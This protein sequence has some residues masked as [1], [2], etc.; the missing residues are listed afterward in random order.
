MTELELKYMIDGEEAFE[1]C[2]DALKKLCGPGSVRLQT[3]YYYDTPKR[4]LHKAGVTL[5]I[6]QNR[7]RM[8]GQVKRHDGGR[9]GKS[10]ESYFLVSELPKYLLFEGKKA[11]LLGSLTTQR[12]CFDWHG[13]E[14]DLDAN[15]YL[16][17]TDYELEIEYPAGDV[18][19]AAEIAA[20]LSDSVV[21]TASRGG[22][23]SRFLKALKRCAK[24]TRCINNTGESDTGDNDTGDNDTG[25]RPDSD[26]TGDRPGFKQCADSYSSET[27]ESGELK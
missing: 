5:R 16:G 2:L 21:L 20:M 6:R 25:D 23:Y 12:H 14:I 9:S 17:N 19:M 27:F 24:L 15:H 4:E 22:K 3:N 26:N 1:R 13:C 7:G 8:Q 10:E 11:K 18:G